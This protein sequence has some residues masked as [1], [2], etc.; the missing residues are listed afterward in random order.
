[1]PSELDRVRLT[2]VS[3]LH[4]SRIVGFSDTDRPESSLPGPIWYLATKLPQQRHA[5]F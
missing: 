2:L 4:V 1:M 5:C 3:P